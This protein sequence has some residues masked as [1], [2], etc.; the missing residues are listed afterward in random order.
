MVR[1]YKNIKND[2][3]SL[4]MKISS[5]EGKKVSFLLASGSGVSS[6]FLSNRPTGSYNVIWYQFAINNIGVYIF[7]VYCF[8]SELG[9]L[10]LPSVDIINMNRVLE[11]KKWFDDYSRKH[12]LKPQLEK[13]HKK[14]TEKNTQPQAAVCLYFLC[15]VLLPE[16]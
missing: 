6:P 14:H 8:N 10:F 12:L 7:Y 3:K 4:E 2:Q 13:H 1:F 15:A 5:P 9:L 16:S 11:R